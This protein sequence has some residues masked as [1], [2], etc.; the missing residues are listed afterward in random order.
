METN[1]GRA[2]FWDFIR[3]EADSVSDLWLSDPVPVLGEAI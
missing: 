3:F 2:A 1:G